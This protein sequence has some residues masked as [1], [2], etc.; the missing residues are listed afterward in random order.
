MCR[1]REEDGTSFKSS[2]AQWVDV[3]TS[4]AG[5]KG[6]AESYVDH[7]GPFNIPGAIR[8][9]FPGACLHLHEP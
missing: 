2:L 8:H 7:A 1:E 6:L 4:Y 9:F 3:A 5:C